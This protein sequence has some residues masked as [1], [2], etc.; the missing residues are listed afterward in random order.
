MVYMSA[1]E[2]CCRLCNNSIP[3]KVYKL[4]GA[5]YS[6]LQICCDCV[7][8]YVECMVSNAH[9]T[10]A[11]TVYKVTIPVAALSMVFV[12]VIPFAGYQGDSC[13][14]HI[15]VAVNISLSSNSA[16]HLLSV[17]PCRVNYKATAC[18]HA[19]M[20]WHAWLLQEQNVVSSSQICG[21]TLDT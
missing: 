11:S 6:S 3:I 7:I 10:T 15:F 9:T 18:I 4:R 16:M 21:G 5:T 20:N 13:L 2:Q 17:L 1:C 19:H 14:S 12:G 8:Q